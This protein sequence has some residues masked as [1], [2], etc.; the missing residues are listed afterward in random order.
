MTRGELYRAFPPA[1]RRRVRAAVDPRLRHFRTTPGLVRIAFPYGR[2]AAIVIERRKGGYDYDKVERPS[3][4][5][6]TLILTPGV[7]G[8]ALH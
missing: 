1:Y 7:S 8:E 4:W 2:S 6:G 5:P 3:R